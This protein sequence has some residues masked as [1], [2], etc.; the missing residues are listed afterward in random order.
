MS[1]ERGSTARECY[2]FTPST[3]G[4]HYVRFV[5]DDDAWTGTATISDEVG[6]VQGTV[7]NGFAQIELN[8]A[9]TYQ[10]DVTGTPS[11]DPT[12]R[13]G[14]FSPASTGCDE[15]LS[16]DFGAPTT[17]GT[18]T[19]PEVDCHVLATP[20]RPR[21]QRPGHRARSAP[22]PPHGRRRRHHLQRQRLRG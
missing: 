3:S 11:G 10:V 7:Y 1:A 13:L 22:E 14:V 5:Q 21:P 19:A 8:Q 20:A 18:L 9:T 15:V 12:Y 17:A 16:T 6:S 4:R 2:Q